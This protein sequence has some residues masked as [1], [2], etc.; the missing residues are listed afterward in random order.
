MD[1]ISLE[2]RLRIRPETNVQCYKKQ[3]IS[4]PTHDF[5]INTGSICIE[6]IQTGSGYSTKHI[7]M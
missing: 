5:K 2:K 3:L 4:I 7:I 6:E 1:P